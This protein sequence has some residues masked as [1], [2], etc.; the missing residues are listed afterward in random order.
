MIGT[1]MRT[2]KEQKQSRKTETGRNTLYT[3]GH[4]HHDIERFLEILAK[5]GITLI[6]DVRSMPYSV[7][8]PQYNRE[9]LEQTLRQ[10]AIKYVFFGNELGGRPRDEALYD[11]GRVNYERVRQ[12]KLFQKGINRVQDA[13]REKV[14]ALLCAEEDPM[15]CH[16]GLMV[17]PALLECGIC[18][19]HL[20]G[21]GSAESTAEFEARLLSETKVGAG[22]L[23]GLF[24]ETLPA[25]ERQ[26]L[27][28]DAYRTQAQKKAFR[29]REGETSP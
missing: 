16:R 27:L 22:M 29:V 18:P 3:L 23:D 6:A 2:A 19:T 1:I 15:V 13:L 21:D 14:V 25:S 7:W 8:L 26:Q 9:T 20:R 28:A 17:T 10:H 11:Q 24:A 5:A 4:S 12:T